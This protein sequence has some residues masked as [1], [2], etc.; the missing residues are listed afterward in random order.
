MV[1]QRINIGVIGGG[2]IGKLHVENI[3][4]NLPDVNV[5]ILVDIKTDHLQ[6][7]ASEMGIGELSTNVD[8]VFG[9][10]EI[11]AVLIFSSTDTHVKFIKQAAKSGK[12]IFCEKPIGSDVD[13]IKNALKVVDESGVKLMIG[14]NR[15]FDHNFS[16]VRKAVDD[17]NVGKPH[18]IK[19]T[20]RDPA[21]PP[22][23]YVKVSGGLFFDMT[24]HDW[25][26]ARFLANSEVSE[27]YATGQVM[28]SE[29]I[30]DI[31]IDTA[32]AIL[33]YEDGSMGMIDNSRQAVYG[34]DQRVEVFGSDGA[35]I[36]ENDTPN[37]VTIYN[38]NTTQQDKIHYFFLDRYT[39][40]YE[41]EIKS[42]FECIKNDTKP[43]VTGKDGLKAVLIA[44]AAQKSL[45]EN[46][47]V[48]ISEVN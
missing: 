20:S 27:V 18:L 23:D 35:A 34:Y 13:N 46:R 4:K 48:K 7:W 41:D 9:D 21:P 45:E 47:P 10:D 8:D 15:R 16:R 37:N 5:K 43:P 39:Q 11:Q 14:F 40:S 1:N 6:D 22:L 25:D 26:M 38:S 42:F 33:K 30:K 24:I 32:A 29:E 36:A 2:R 28:I 44:M 31:D 17:G 19:I 12:D 3:V